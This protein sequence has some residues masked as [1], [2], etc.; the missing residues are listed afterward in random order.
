MMKLSGDYM[1][2]VL[3]NRK[4]I[5]DDGGVIIA[6][7]LDLKGASETIDRGKLTEKILAFHKVSLGGSNH[8][9]TVVVNVQ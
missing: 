3:A 8:V 4:D 5:L 9:W 1:N 7:I 6:V 2:L